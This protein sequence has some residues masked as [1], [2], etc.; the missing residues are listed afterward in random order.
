MIYYNEFKDRENQLYKIELDTKNG[1][2][3]TEFRTSDSPIEIKWN[4]DNDNI[5]SPLR[6]SNAT[7]EIIADSATDLKEDLYTGKRKGV[8]ARLYRGNNLVW[9]GWA[10][11]NNYNSDYQGEHDRMQIEC[12]DILKCMS[13]IPYRATQKII[14]SVRDIIL[15]CIR[16]AS[17]IQSGYLYMADTLSISGIHS[18]SVLSN[19]FLPE[20]LFFDDK[21]DNET[22]DDV[23]WK[24][25]E[26]VEAICLWLNMI[27]VQWG[28]D[29][30]L[31]DIDAIK[32]KDSSYKRMS[33]ANGTEQ[34]VTLSNIVQITSS[35]YGGSDNS[36]SKEGL[37]NK[38]KVRDRFRTFESVIPSLYD[39]LVNITKDSDETLQSSSNYENGMYGEV[40]SSNLG[41]GKSH[42]N[43]IN[44]VDRV[45]SP[46]DGHY[47]DFNFVAVKYFNNTFYK[48]FKYDS[49]G[50]EITDSVTSLNYT[51]TKTMYGATIARFDVKKLDKLSDVALL[52]QYVQNK[53]K[54]LDQW[55]SE[56]GISSISLENYVELLN[57]TANHIQNEQMETKPFLESKTAN[58]SAFFGGENAYLI[59]SGSY[60]YHYQD[61]DPYP[62]P[63]GEVDIAEGRY[64]IDDNNGYMLAKLEWGGLYWNGSEWTSTSSTFPIRY[65]VSGASAG[66]RRADATMYK[67]IQIVS[68]VSWRYG[69]NEKGYCIPVPPDRVIA[70]MPKITLYKPFDPNYHSVKSGSNKGRHYL[71]TRVFLKDF[72]IKAV[73]GDPTYS[74]RT[75]KDTVYSNST[76]DSQNVNDFDDVEFRVCTYDGKAPNYSSVVYKDSN[77]IYRYVSNVTSH[78]HT[79]PQE[80]HMVRR[81]VTQYGHPATRLKLSL[82][83]SFQPWTLFTESLTNK[84]YFLD[85][86]TWRVGDSVSDVEIRE[87]LSE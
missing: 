52:I 2:T 48:L 43:M 75:Q 83:G 79:E 80:A 63:E 22:D 67:D 46:D 70:G 53:Q 28:T 50:H 24:L 44:M 74:D 84:E 58:L 20:S 12:S 8:E 15:K 23:A 45:Y 36:I 81:I 37:F 41:D 66:D 71:H 62:I 5:Y 85:C 64:A 39:N 47:K 31:L 78:G 77:N 40:V 65:L 30:Y 29:F 7:I 32:A 21:E 61:D 82:R 9:Y 54:T 68:N 27:I 76:S 26:V 33:I 18:G 4:S 25:S 6:G 3:R 1:N 51:D 49:Q 57:P 55:L 38:V 11:P 10:D 69:I 35:L 13:D 59:I 34:S 19:L 56:N 87:I 73:V 16:D 42:G 72:D 17:G 86:A 14:K 60:L